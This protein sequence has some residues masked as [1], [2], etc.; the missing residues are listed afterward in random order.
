MMPWQKVFIPAASG[1]SSGY[2]V[3]TIF[4][5]CLH[6]IH[7]LHICNSQT[8][9]IIYLSNERKTFDKCLNFFIPSPL[10]NASPGVSFFVPGN[11]IPS[12][13][14]LPSPFTAMPKQQPHYI[15]G[16]AAL[17]IIRIFNCQKLISCIRHNCNVACTFNSN[18]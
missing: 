1:M 5:I 2:G 9:N 11:S 12:C 18:C 15:N 3:K 7:S 10:R 13:N 8:L 6:F 14:I 17:L 16:T 4:T